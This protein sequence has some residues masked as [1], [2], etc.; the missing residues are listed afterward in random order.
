MERS[1]PRPTAYVV[2]ASQPWIDQLLEILSHHNAEHFRLPAGSAVSLQQYYYIEPDGSKSCIAGLLDAE[3]VTFENG[4]I[5]IPMDQESG[6]VIGMLMEPDVGD[7]AQYNGTLYQYGLVGYD[8]TT[9][10]IPIY[11][12]TGND[13]HTSLLE[14]SV[15]VQP[16]PQVPASGNSYTVKAG[17]S[18]WKIAKNVL[19]SGTEW[20][21]LYEANKDII[22]NPNFIQVGQVLTVPAQ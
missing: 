7:S 21:R 18:L 6:T 15:P 22:A 5:A 11:R 3:I 9:K 14:N 13:P 12:Y 2:D 19:G 10:N 4:A 16:D 8:E 20:T 1:R 17:D